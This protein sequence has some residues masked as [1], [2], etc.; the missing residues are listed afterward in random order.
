MLFSMR[1]VKN[2]SV[3]FWL[4]GYRFDSNRPLVGPA[5]IGGVPSVGV[6]LRNSR[7][8]L[9]DFFVKTTFKEILLK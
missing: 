2:L 1:E 8:Y 4:V 3:H 6:F 5:N 9:R 7:P